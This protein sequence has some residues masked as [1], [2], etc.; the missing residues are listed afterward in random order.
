MIEKKFNLICGDC[1]SEMPKLFTQGIKVDMILADLPYGQTQNDWDSIIPLD[2]L[3]TQ[4]RKIIKANGAIVL[5]AGQPFASELI[6]SNKKQYRYDL[7][8][9]KKGKATGF[10]NA[11]RMPLRSH[12]HILIFYTESPAY[13]PQKTKG[14]INHSKGSHSRGKKQTNNNYGKFNQDFQSAPTTD[15][16]PLSVLE[17][18]SVH[19][20][21]HPTEKP[22]DLMRWLILTYTNENEIVLDNTMGSGPTG[23]AC[24]KTGRQFIGIEKEQKYFEIAEHRI[25]AEANQTKLFV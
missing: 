6:M 21:I 25:S 13:N 9:F 2:E 4:Y 17:F 22:V 5:T 1:L 15:K 20:P 10:L 18:N 14:G 3:W 8:W 23:I 12:E 7:I 16:F 11:N 24:M 19:P